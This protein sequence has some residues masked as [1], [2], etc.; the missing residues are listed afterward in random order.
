MRRAAGWLA[1]AGALLLLSPSRGP[2][3][4]AEPPAGAPPEL[5][6]GLGTPRLLPPPRPGP[7]RYAELPPLRFFNINTELSLAV[8]LYDDSG[9][10]DEAAAVRLDEHLADRRRPGR[11]AEIAPLDRR[12]VRLVARAAY[13][14]GAPEIEVISAYRKPWRYAEGMHGKA[15]AMD[16]RLVGVEAPELATYLRQQPLVGVGLYTHPK[17]RFV[18]LDVRDHSYHWVDGTRPGKRWGESRLPTAG[19]DAIDALYEASDDLPEGMGAQPPG[20][21]SPRGH[22]DPASFNAGLEP[23][24]DELRARCSYQLNQ[25]NNAAGPS[26]SHPQP[27]TL[28]R[29]S[30][31]ARAPSR[32]SRALQK[33]TP[34]PSEAQIWYRHS[35][36]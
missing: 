26:W 28:A 5:D 9:Q 14:F 19:L 27:R 17:T 8:R 16:F 30:P 6:L 31:P 11:P 29:P 33:K 1:A 36:R 34:R 25:S 32:A 13:R 12:L 4:L 3:P 21:S 24:A 2:A 15:R 20:E 23:A 35:L 10:L 22:P 18:H 7:H